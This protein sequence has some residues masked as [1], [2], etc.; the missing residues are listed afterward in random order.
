QPVTRP[1]PDR[2][3]LPVGKIPLK[4]LSRLLKRYSAPTLTRSVVIGPSIGIDCAVLDCGGK[5]FLLAKTDPITF[6]VEDM[7]FYAIHINATDIA[8]MGGTPRWF[9]STVLLPEGRAA[10]R[11]AERIFAGIS[12]ACLQLGVSFCGGHT[13]VARGVERPVIVGQMLG[14]VPRKRLV[15]SAGGRRNDDIIL[16]KG[17]ALEAASIIAREKAGA[18]KGV[19]SEGFMKKCRG[20]VRN[21]GIS[22]VK[23]ARIALNK[24]RVHA[25]HDPTEGGLSAGL[26]ELAIASNVGML[27][28]GDNI[29]LVPES[30]E[31][32]WY[33]G[34][35][36]M[37]AIASG[38]LLL[39]VDPRDTGRIIAGLKESGIKSARIGSVTDKRKG[40]RIIEAGKEKR[41]KFYERDEITRLF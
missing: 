6:V 5:K 34:L 9:L 35:D 25:M 39:T 4:F 8:V 27:I 1:S 15:S 3:K 2:K 19:F 20:F 28:E 7:G 18:L 11:D 16:T 30:V 37:G 22:V 23:D 12:R 17:I 36:P 31:L 24:G 14:T 32:L 41:L 21:P 26:Y 40:V 33:F 13:E 29:P 38:A 10:Q